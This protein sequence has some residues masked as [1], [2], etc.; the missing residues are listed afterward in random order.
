MVDALGAAVT[1]WV[2]VVSTRVGGS[3]GFFVADGVGVGS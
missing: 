3:E 2:V 1:V